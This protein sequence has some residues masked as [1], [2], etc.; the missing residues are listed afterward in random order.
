MRK[1]HTATETVD[2]LRPLKLVFQNKYEKISIFRLLRILKIANQKFR[3]IRVSHD[4][5][6]ATRKLN[7]V[8][9]EEGNTRDGEKSGSFIYKIRGPGSPLEVQ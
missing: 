2:K 3:N 9:I 6:Q 8:L 7:K 4:Y 1:S 5:S